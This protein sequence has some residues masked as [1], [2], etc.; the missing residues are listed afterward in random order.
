MTPMNTPSRNQPC[1]C[2]SGK[3]Y[4]H[5][6]GSARGAAQSAP[7]AQMVQFQQLVQTALAHHQSGDLDAAAPLYDQALAMRPD[8]SGLL[9]LKGMLLLQ[10]GEP[11]AALPLIDHGL[12]LSPNDARLHNYRGQVFAAQGK[13][14]YAEAAFV[15]ALQLDADYFDAWFNAGKLFLRKNKSGEAI[16]AL[17]RAKQLAPKDTEIGLLLAEACF[18]EN[19]P[20]EAEAELRRVGADKSVRGGLW[21]AAALHGLGQEE[22]AAELEAQA[23]DTGQPGIVFATSCAIGRAQVHI[24]DL[25]AAEVSLNRAIALQ[26]QSPAPYADLAAARK[27]S[28]ADAPLVATMESLREKAPE[29]TQR[30]LEFALGKVYTD[31]G[32]FDRSFEHYHVANDLVRRKVPFDIAR[33][34]ARIDREIDLFSAERLASMP[35]GSDSDVPIVIVGTP[36]SGTTLTESIISSHSQVAGAGEMSFW[37]A[38]MSHVMPGFPDSYTPALARQLADEYLLFMRQHSASARRITD[39]M[40]GNYMHVGMIHAVFPNAKIIHTKRHPIDACLSIYFQNF[41]DGHEYKWDLESLAAWYEQYQRL[42]AH[43]R[44]VL[45]PGVLYE[46]QYEDLVEDQEGESR[47][48]LEFLGLD[49]ED[50]V[51]EF[52]KQER[53]VYTASK[54]QVRQPVYKTSTERWRRYEKHLGPLMDL[55]KYA[56]GAA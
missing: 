42:M 13:D 39:K 22:A 30:G 56:P 50:G 35:R 20:A 17:S 23:L 26:P 15:R 46:S 45:P 1:P 25:K 44:A 5:C 43:W 28:A 21:L 41:P 38:A 34:A 18:L 53:A 10:Q 4:K 33:Y 55:L 36:R 7:A 2:G 19:R 40:P 48:L 31:M 11:D 6:C 16:Q 37:S 32:D 3:K 12:R 47:K 52:H 51:L 29:E 9:G 14:G 49:W 27:F 54:W 24:G 8:D